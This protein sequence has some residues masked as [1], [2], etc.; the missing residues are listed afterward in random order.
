MTEKWNYRFQ[1]F[2]NLITLCALESAYT[3]IALTLAGSSGSYLVKS[4]MFRYLSLDPDA[5][6]VPFYKA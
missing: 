4:R 6:R 5:K 2:K 3:F 1:I